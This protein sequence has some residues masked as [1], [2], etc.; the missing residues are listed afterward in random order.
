MNKLK[1][2]R[3]I[4]STTKLRHAFERLEMGGF[5]EEVCDKKEEQEGVYVL[6][7]LV[8]K[9]FPFFLKK[10][11]YDVKLLK[12]HAVVP[13]SIDEKTRHEELMLFTDTMLSY[14]IDALKEKKPNLSLEKEYAFFKKSLHL[15]TPL[16][17]IFRKMKEKG[18][19]R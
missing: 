4:K 5:L 1:E 18:E 17:D 3:E 2:K 9:Y 15:W 12:G 14:M 13:K 6:V 19:T 8:N 11:G 7:N 16:N 10:R